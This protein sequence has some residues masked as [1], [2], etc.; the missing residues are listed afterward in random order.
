MKSE[1]CTPPASADEGVELAVRDL[2]R[3]WTPVA[4]YYSNITSDRRKQILIGNFQDGSMMLVNIRGY[5]VPT[6]TI[7]ESHSTV[8]VSLEIC[9]PELLEQKQVQFR[10]LET[11]RYENSRVLPDVWVLD[12]VFIEYVSGNIR[13]PLVQDNF[14]SSN[15]K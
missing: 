6:T 4:Y 15:L 8:F 13:I 12:D 9:D 1:D 3:Q 11:A 2:R 7:L 14:N 5:A 10:W